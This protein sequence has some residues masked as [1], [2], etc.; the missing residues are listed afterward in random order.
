MCIGYDMRY[1]S[2]KPI[3]SYN[4]E[5]VRHAGGP[6]CRERVK[7][8]DTAH[9]L[10]LTS[11]GD[12]DSRTIVNRIM[13][14]R[15][16]IGSRISHRKWEF[17]GSL[18]RQ[19]RDMLAFS[20]NAL[21]RIIASYRVS[22]RRQ[23]IPSETPCYLLLELPTVNVNRELL[24]GTFGLACRSVVAIAHPTTRGQA[25]QIYSP[26]EGGWMGKRR[27]RTGSTERQND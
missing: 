10:F 12:P 18:W 5:L 21:S 19:T 24:D 14:D 11:L 6:W 25:R 23:D 2:T 4:I 16:W 15:P 22:A 8:E 1:R 9:V 17:S 7:P 3:T 13:H 26:G 20:E 27:T